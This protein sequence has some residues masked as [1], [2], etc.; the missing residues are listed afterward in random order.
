MVIMLYW[1]LASEQ[2]TGN[3]YVTNSRAELL[4]LQYT[5]YEVLNYSWCS[6]H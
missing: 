2:H 5:P 6:G 4:Y 3:H 1:N